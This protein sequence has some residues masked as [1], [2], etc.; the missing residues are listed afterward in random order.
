MI[1]QCCDL[2][3]LGEG[4][5]R[6]G[7]WKLLPKVF[8]SSSQRQGFLPGKGQAEEK[9]AE[10]CGSPGGTEGQRVSA[11]RFRGFDGDPIPVSWGKV[12]RYSGKGSREREIPAG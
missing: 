12:V 8:R 3:S 11:E 10:I 6:K 4:E 2:Q 7:R 1:V 9:A 5:G